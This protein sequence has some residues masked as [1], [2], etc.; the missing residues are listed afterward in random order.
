MTKQFDIMEKQKTSFDERMSLSTA[1]E[2]MKRGC[3]GFDRWIV[4]R[5]IITT[6]KTENKE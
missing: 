1:I 4:E 5:V 3:N 2:D 6:E